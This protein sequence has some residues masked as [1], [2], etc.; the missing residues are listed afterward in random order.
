MDDFN[1]KATQAHVSDPVLFNGNVQSNN[2]AF[3]I[4]EYQR[5]YVWSRR[6]WE[7][8]FDDIIDN[9]DGHFVGA[10]I[11]VEQGAT[12]DGFCA[13]Q[14][15][16]DGQQ[17]LTTLSLLLAAIYDA[18]G[19]CE[20]SADEVDIRRQIGRQLTVKLSGGRIRP[21]VYPHNPDN[22]KDY[23]LILSGCGLFEGYELDFDEPLGELDGRRPITKA[24]RYF[25]KRIEM[26]AE[27]GLEGLV[28][29]YRLVNATVIVRIL[30]GSHSNANALFETL[31]GRGVP[32]AITDLIKNRLF[33]ALKKDAGG[34]AKSL[35]IWDV[36]MEP[37]THDAAGKEISGGEQERFFRQ[38]YNAFRSE[39]GGDAEFG[40]GKRA[41]LFDL[42]VKMIDANCQRVLEQISE[43]ARIYRQLQ[44]EV[45]SK[46]QKCFQDLRRINGATSYTLL[47]YLEK[48]RQ[49]LGLDDADFEK[50]CRLLIKFFVRHSFT[51]T[52]SSNTLDGIFI[53]FVGEIEK[54]S[55]K[56][57]AIHENLARVL[58]ERYKVDAGDERFKVALREATFEKGSND[59]L[60]FVLVK[61]AEK[62]FKGVA[63]NFWEMEATNG[64]IRRQQ[65]VWTIEHILPQ[66]LNAA[67]IKILAGGNE[68]A[69]KKIHEEYVHRL[70]NLT[71][72]QNNVEIGNKIFVEKKKLDYDGE[73]FLNSKGGLNEWICAQTEWTPEK[74]DAR[75]A[76]L[77]DSIAEIF[78]W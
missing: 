47:L 63:P 36:A 12:A 53:G 66:S 40:I 11:C 35:K 27:G 46:L 74:I 78:A 76:M 64:Q 18:F 41:N 70:G 2:V 57:A 42:Y 69:A 1:I 15:V 7:A 19:R 54:N 60:R 48:N 17:R 62:P 16:V 33:A 39:W 21:R 3:N 20:L 67:W 58:K 32:L 4:P 22:V 71:L 29:L 10:I 26:Y 5:A 73:H 61:L 31:N 77:A 30:A 37:I 55:Y 59:A 34:Y 45:F 24:Y 52:P 13:I 50:I 43:S 65:F 51:S 6:D 44:G 25:C 14:E 23:L 72:T 68:T 8:L 28:R 49:A 38:S 9:P 75:T 56:G